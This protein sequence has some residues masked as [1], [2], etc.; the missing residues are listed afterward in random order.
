MT[1]LAACSNGQ[2]STQEVKFNRRILRF[3]PSRQLFLLPILLPATETST[4]EFTP[5]PK[6]PLEKDAWMK[7]PVVPTGVSDRARE[8]YQLGLVNGQ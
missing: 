8:I 7:M 3:P 1:L 5:T 2:V 6:P 4:P